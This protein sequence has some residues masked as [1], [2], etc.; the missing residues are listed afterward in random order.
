VV[1]SGG[2]SFAMKR[3]SAQMGLAGYMSEQVGA[4]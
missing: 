2:H 4:A 3:L 1:I